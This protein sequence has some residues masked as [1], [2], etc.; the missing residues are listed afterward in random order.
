MTQLAQQENTAVTEPKQTAVSTTV[1]DFGADA[2][3]G[4]ENTT[5]ESFAIPF[6]SVLQSNSPQVTEGDAKFIADARPGM[7]LNTVTGKLY[8]GKVGALFVQSAYRRAFLEWGPRQGEGA[9]FQ[10]EH[11]AEEIQKL[12]DQKAIVEMEGRLYRPL[13]DGSVNAKR[14][15]SFRDTRMHYGLLIEDEV[16][17]DA[18]PVLLSLSSTQI[19]KSKQL[20]S[21]LSAVKV[22][23]ANG[24]K[25]SPPTFASIVRITTVPESNDQGNWFGVRFAIEK[26]VESKAVYDAAKEFYKMVM[27]G[28]VSANHE[29]D[30]GAAPTAEQDDGGF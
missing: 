2:G 16:S 9:G 20:M 11:T 29:Q 23:L 27:A 18:M 13:Q 24:S 10:G 28:A 25:V 3:A 30:A 5:Q 7:L 17:G 15:N 19:K 1:I 14:C 8:D 6:L 4:M 22:S 12:R 26:R 21:A